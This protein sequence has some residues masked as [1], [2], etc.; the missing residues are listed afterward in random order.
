MWR[1]SW[2]RIALS[3][4][5][6]STLVFAVS[7]PGLAGSSGPVSLEQILANYLRA[8]NDPD[9]APVVRLESSGTVSGAGL[10]GPFHTWMD[11]DNERDDQNLGPR[12]ESVV[13][14]HGEVYDRDAN[15]AVRH[16]TGLMLRRSRTDRFIDSGDF[17]KFPERVKLQGQTT[18]AGRNAYVLDVSAEGGEVETL[19]IDAQTWL[20]LRIAYDDDDGRTTIDL[21]DW[22][23]VD[24]HRFPFVSVESDG[25]KAYDITETT[26]ETKLAVPID[27]ALFVPPISRAIEMSAADSVPLRLQGGHLFAPVTIAGKTYS[28]LVD[29][30]AQDV[31]VDTHIVREAGLTAE[32]ALEASGA[33]RTSGLKLVRIPELDIGSGRMRDIVATSLDLN[34]ATGGAFKIDGIL[35]YPFF[36]AAAV[37]IDPVAMKMTFGVPGSLPIVGDAVP[38]ETDRSF[39]EAHARLNTSVDGLFIVDTGNAGSMLLYGPFYAK[40][41]AL[42]D[43]PTTWRQNYGIGGAAGSMAANLNT[44]EFGGV[45]LYHVDTDIM[46][47]KSGAFADRFDAGNVGL[48]ILLNFI[49]TFDESRN[50]MYLQKSS[51]FDDGRS[52]H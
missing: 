15:G 44:V 4:V 45:S 39:P 37:R 50:A 3:W 22:H 5:A 30:G 18:V 17:A 38:I 36:A 8:T 24:G 47:S 23:S 34:S 14:Q 1:A 13:R 32:G 16:F 33:T 31:V 20:P 2:R 27:A 26:L 7:V 10:T 41:S 11:G 25:D 46:R 40:H 19:Y 52:K 9:A 29:T 43:P 28:F 42:V 49:M 35:G 12:F 51:A 21:S 6:S 48:G